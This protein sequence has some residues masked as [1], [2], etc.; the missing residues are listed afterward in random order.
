MMFSFCC[1][2]T[3]P[4][5]W[6]FLLNNC[7]GNHKLKIKVLKTNMKKRIKLQNLNYIPFVDL[8][9][10][11]KV[12]TVF[13]HTSAKTSEEKK[14]ER[15]TV[16]KNEKQISTE[17]AL[18]NEKEIQTIIQHLIRI[19]HI[20]FGWIRDFDKLVFNYVMFLYFLFSFNKK[21]ISNAYCVIIHI[22]KLIQALLYSYSIRFLQL[23]NYSKH[24]IDTK[25]GCG[26]LIVQHLIVITFICS[27][28]KDN[29][30]RVWDFDSNEQIQSLYKH[31][32]NVYCVKFSQY[33]YYNYHRNV[34]CFSSYDNNTYFWDF[35]E[36]KQFQIFDQHTG[37]VGGIEL[38]PFSNG[39]YLCSASEDKTIRLCDV[40]T[41]K[42]LHIFNGHINAV[43]CVDISPLQSNN[44]GNK[45]NS[46]GM[47]G[48][49]GYTICSGSDDKT[50]R[51]W[52]I[53]TTKQLIVFKGHE[54]WIMSVKYGSNELGNI[55]CAN[56]ILSGSGDKSVRLWD[57]RSGQQIQVFNG[58]ENRVI[59][60][61]YSL[62]TVNNNEVSGSSNVICSG[63]WDNTIR[64]WDIRSNKNELYV[65]KGYKR[66]DEGIR[67]LKFLQLKKKNN[68][69]YV[70]GINLCYGTDSESLII[71]ISKK[72]HKHKSRDFK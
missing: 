10:K 7:S 33:H 20:K 51:I 11:K 63:S 2:S 49:N 50:I 62:F 59:A 71:F 14:V 52:D 30:V 4:F 70:C 22:I 3:S 47:I 9:K 37:G 54:N 27:G 41:S 56:T 60:A 17:L 46:I 66:K 15:M 45:S 29:T 48:G 35:K 18:S 6:E 64:F 25:I 19:L 39:R 61:E 55:G 38:S 57:I 42:S 72:I 5:F 44:N 8:K 13:H 58:H 53:E 32:S 12:Q 21:Q 16:I 34:I 24:F 69:N 31:S 40:E 36:N 28:S 67:C 65:I 23:L 26:V 43:W 68:C 1:A